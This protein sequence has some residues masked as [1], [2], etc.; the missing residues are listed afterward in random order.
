MKTKFKKNIKISIAEI[1]I[2]FE[3]DYLP[4]EKKIN[5]ILENFIV[6]TDKV[7]I[8]IKLN[9]TESYSLVNERWDY[10]ITNIKDNNIAIIK[11][12]DINGELNINKNTDF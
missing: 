10:F 6:E 11:K 12:W 3:F 4:F 7:D 9:K 8:D 5:D 1:I 2:S